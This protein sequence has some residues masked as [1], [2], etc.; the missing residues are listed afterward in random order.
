MAVDTQAIR[1]T[2]DH[3]LETASEVMQVLNMDRRLPNGRESYLELLE[4]L[5][6]RSNQDGGDQ[7]TQFVWQGQC[8]I[9]GDARVGKT[10]LKKSLTGEAFNVE[11]RR[12]KGVEVSLVDRKWKTSDP[13]TGLSFGSFARFTESALYKWVFYGPGGA[14]F[15]MTENRTSLFCVKWFLLINW[16][17]SFV[18]LLC[19]D[20]MSATFR[21][22][23]FS[24]SLIAVL[25]RFFFFIEDPV[26]AL[27]L[28]SIIA[29]IPRFIVGL[30]TSYLLSGLRKGTDCC[31][32]KFSSP[33]HDSWCN[34]YVCVP[35]FLIFAVMWDY[36]FFKMLR[37]GRKYYL[38]PVNL[39]GVESTV[40]GQATFEDS[41][42]IFLRILIFILPII[43]GF[44]F[45]CII[46]LSVEPS[47]YRYCVIIHCLAISLFCYLICALAK[48]VLNWQGQVALVLIL[49]LSKEKA[50]LSLFSFCPISIYMAMFAVW[51]C[52]ML[53]KDW[54]EMYPLLTSI[55]NNGET[56]ASIIFILIENCILNFRKLKAALQNTF[57]C[58]KLKLLDFAGDEEYYAYHNI[59]MRDQAI[60]I[61]VF[62]MANFSD[63][64]FRHIETKIQR[65]RFWLESICSKARPKTPIFL[66]GTH[67]GHMDT[68]HLKAIDKHL[69]RHLTHSF[70]D[71]LVMNKEDKLLYFPT[72]N[73]LGRNDRGIQNLQKE[74]MSTAEELRP[75]MGREIP[76]S[77]IKIQDA[78]INLSENRNAKFCVPLRQ[79]PISVGNFICSN[80]SRE[81]LKYFHEK[82]LVIYNHD[83]HDSQLSSWI[84]LKPAILV[85]IITQLVSP[86]TDEEVY[87]QRGFRRDWK[88][89]HDTGMLTDSLLKHILSRFQENEEAMKGF[90]EEYDIICPL[91]FNATNQE[92]EAQVTH[93]VPS[94]LPMSSM[95]TV[96]TPPVWFDGPYDKTFYVFFNR[97]LPQSVF[98]HLLSRAHKNSK[99]EF[100]HG[101]PVICQDVGRFWLWPNQPYRLL[102]LKDEDMIEVKFTYK[103]LV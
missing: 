102:R 26:Q 88:L 21:I 65:L 38:N 73:R 40:P 17:I 34:Q 58:V 44:S 10:S 63:N 97:F 91:F 93:F 55:G 4:D 79:F 42:P 72:E 8:L 15:V 32:I 5:N 29:N 46:G 92:E 74:I 103:R 28:F 86:L 36:I 78:I 18:R 19:L 95:A 56:R 45:G 54:D 99:A 98:Q 14:K 43:S 41:E 37:L 22:F 11:E 68:I 3:T 2:N 69:Q 47:E 67:R 13:T 70:S 83:R 9:L 30:G 49:Y 6:F 64:N 53:Y 50:D 87:F 48:T 80:W 59:F 25:L 94:L 100:A 61:V 51:A 16:V 31:N 1:L 81:T 90:L 62:N 85:D 33:E 20:E 27:I 76:Y 71:E 96:T 101:Q 84:L 60:Y 77:W 75:I 23:F 82:G 12:T 7:H 35:Q 57:C 52:H 39:S 89:L 66:V 24:T